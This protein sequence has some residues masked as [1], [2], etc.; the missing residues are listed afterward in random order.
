MKVDENKVSYATLH[1]VESDWEQLRNKTGKNTK[2]DALKASVDAILT[3]K[4]KGGK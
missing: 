3:E 1:L 4:K 2:V